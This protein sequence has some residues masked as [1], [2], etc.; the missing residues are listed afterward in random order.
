MSGSV[1]LFPASI[2][3][4]LPASLQ[5]TTGHSAQPLSNPQ[6]A[7][8][9]SLTL[10]QSPSFLSH[11]PCHSPSRSMSLSLTISLSIQLLMQLSHRTTHS[12]LLSLL[13]LLASRLLFPTPR[14]SLAFSHSF[15]LRTSLTHVAPFLTCSRTLILAAILAFSLHGT[16][17][18]ATLTVRRTL[19]STLSSH[20]PSTH[21]PLSRHPVRVTLSY[22][23]HVLSLSHR[24]YKYLSMVIADPHLVFASRTYTRQ[25][26]LS[27]PFLSHSSRSPLHS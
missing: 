13:S 17:P 5:P 7:A 21:L 15:C 4:A 20:S 12:C 16:L 19:P 2:R 26:S 23:T 10:A 8:H 25:R 1:R 24:H 9:S 11:P 3:Q 6:Q 14:R 27:S 18:F 22:D